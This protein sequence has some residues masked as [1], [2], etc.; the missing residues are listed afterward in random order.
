MKQFPHVAA[1]LA[2]SR[3][4][5]HDQDDG[6]CDPDRYEPEQGI[7]RPSASEPLLNDLISAQQERSRDGQPERVGGLEVD[8][9]DCGIVRPRA[10][11]VLRLMTSSNFVGYAASLTQASG[12]FR[13]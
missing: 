9:T 4:A 5:A 7:V 11:A 3:P 6:Q 13:R 1:F 12:L 2:H 8:H 10:L